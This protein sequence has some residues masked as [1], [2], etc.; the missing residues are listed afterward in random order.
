MV[1]DLSEGCHWQWTAFICKNGFLWQGSPWPTGRNILSIGP[2]TNKKFV[3][4]TRRGKRCRVHPRGGCSTSLCQASARWFRRGDTMH[5]SLFCTCL[6]FSTA[7]PIDF[8][9]KEAYQI[10]N[11]FGSTGLSHDAKCSYSVN[12]MESHGFIHFFFKSKHAVKSL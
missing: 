3:K 8:K 6:L 9:I 10:N 1:S 2:L 7:H 5:G 12:T 4:T 11:T